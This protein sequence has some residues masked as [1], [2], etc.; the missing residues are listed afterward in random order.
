M[1]TFL[2]HP[3][4]I[5]LTTNCLLIPKTIGL[6]NQADSSSAILSES[7]ARLNES[8]GPAAVPIAASAAQVHTG[9]NALTNEAIRQ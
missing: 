5:R 6:V 9:K 7:E 3:A 1:F 8:N 4:Q 2:S